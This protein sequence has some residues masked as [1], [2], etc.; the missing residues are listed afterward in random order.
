MVVDGSSFDVQLKRFMM[1]RDVTI[2]PRTE[3]MV[4]SR[5]RAAAGRISHV[6]MIADGQKMS[7]QSGA[8]KVRAMMRYIAQV[9]LE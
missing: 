4:P 5:I 7:C 3:A 2:A 8:R 6:E 1:R 9:F